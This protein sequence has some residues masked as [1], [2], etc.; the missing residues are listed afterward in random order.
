MRGEVNSHMS[1]T[2]GVASGGTRDSKAS[3]ASWFD[4]AWVVR[5]D[6]SALNLAQLRPLR[7][8]RVSCC[9]IAGA[10]ARASAS[11]AV[12]VGSSQLCCAIE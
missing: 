11:S 1:A 7:S 9:P 12:V 10:M 6:P 8:N 5:P 3:S 2:L 4:G